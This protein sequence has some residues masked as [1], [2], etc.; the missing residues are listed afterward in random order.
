MVAGEAGK[1]FFSCG[2]CRSNDVGLLTICP[3]RGVLR[4][5]LNSVRD[6]AAFLEVRSA[7]TLRV[8]L[9]AAL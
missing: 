7:S 1:F 3:L 4:R 8:V 6:E 2:W 5:T 9:H